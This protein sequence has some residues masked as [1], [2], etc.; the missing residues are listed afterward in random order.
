MSCLESAWKVKYSQYEPHS[1]IRVLNLQCSLA[2]VR[3]AWGRHPVSQPALISCTVSLKAPFTLTVLED[4]VND[5]TVHYGT[6]SKSILEACNRYSNANR[7]QTI[8]LSHLIYFIQW[9][10]TGIDLMVES[11]IDFPTVFLLNKTAIELLTLEVVLPKASLLG[12]GVKMEGGFRYNESNTA[13]STYFMTFELSDLRIPTLIG[14]NPNERL[15][16]QIVNVT[17]QIDYFTSLPEEFFMLEQAITKSVTESSY[18]TLEALSKQVGDSVDAI[19]RPNLSNVWPTIRVK[20]SKPTA[21]T[22]AEFPM[23]EMLINTKIV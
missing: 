10:L 18:Q 16:R 1:V 7:E 4:A 9:W 2:T 8:M 11:N 20:L 6:L 15:A 3:D 13:I 14:V 22:L 23:I 12:S 21:V 19:L 5:T 17:V